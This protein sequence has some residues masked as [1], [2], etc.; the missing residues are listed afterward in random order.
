MVVVIFLIH[1]LLLYAQLLS[2]VATTITMATAALRAASGRRLA[3]H[4]SDKYRRMGQR[5]D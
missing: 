3:A 2:S 5:D 1:R 4:R